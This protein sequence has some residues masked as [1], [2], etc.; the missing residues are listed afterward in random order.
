M[1]EELMQELK[2]TLPWLIAAALVVGGWY[3]WKNYTTS[4]KVAA[5]EAVV[6]AFTVEELEE[7]AAKYAS[8]DAGGALKLRLAKKY[9]DGERYQQAMDLYDELAA[10]PPEGFADVTA[11]GRAQCL[12]AMGKYAEAQQ[13]F[14]AYAQ[15]NPKSFLTLTAQLGAARSMAEAGNKK[16]ALEQLAALKETVKDD[17]LAKMRVEATEDVVTRYKK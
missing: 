9:F 15:A 6:N 8:T 14:E 4:R 3:G 11:V 13:A 2:G 1:N 5:S 16:E 12:E 10:N 7:A 17:M